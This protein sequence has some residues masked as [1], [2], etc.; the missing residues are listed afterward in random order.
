M[1][2]LRARSARILPLLALALLALAG[3]AGWWPATE[4]ETLPA[5]SATAARERAPSGT[6]ARIDE[7]RLREP[8]DGE[9]GAF[10]PLL[11]ATPPTWEEALWA[12]LEVLEADPAGA[13]AW[14][15]ALAAMRAGLRAPDEGWDALLDGLLLPLSYRP[16]LERLA[17][18]VLE[19][20]PVG[21]VGLELALQD[22]LFL[23]ELIRQG[24]EPESAGWLLLTA[25][26]EGWPEDAEQREDLR[27]FVQLVT[28]DEG[29]RE[30]VLDAALLR[31]EA[32]LFLSADEQQEYLDPVRAPRSEGHLREIVCRDCPY[33]DYG[34]L[35][36]SASWQTHSWELKPAEC[37]VYRFVVEA[38]ATYRFSLCD[39][40][41]SASFDSLLTAKSSRCLTLAQD[42]DS[43]GTA[44]EMVVTASERGYLYVQ[45]A[46]QGG[47]GGDYTLAYRREAAGSGPGCSGCPAYD[48]HLG[49]P[50]NQWQSVEGSIGADACRTYRFLLRLNRTYRFKTC[51]PEGSANFDTVIETD[52]NSANCFPGP[53]ND[54]AC[55]PQSSVTLTSRFTQY[56]TVS[57]RGFAGA[58]GDFELAYKD[59]TDECPTCPNYTV[60]AATPEAEWGFVEGQVT[61]HGCDLIRLYLYDGHSY[62]FT[63]CEGD[64]TQFADF[65]TELALLDENCDPLLPDAGAAC[66]PR[67]GLDYTACGDQVVYLRVGDGGGFGGAYRIAATELCGWVA[68]CRQCNVQ[69]GPLT[70]T[71]GWQVEPLNMPSG[72]CRVVAVNLEA[73][74]TYRFST[75]EGGGSISLGQALGLQVRQP[76]CGPCDGAASAGTCA[77]TAPRVDFTPDVTGTYYLVLQELAWTPGPVNLAYTEICADCTTPDNPVPLPIGCTY[78]TLS[79]TVSTGDGCDVWEFEVMPGQTYRFTLCP[80]DSDGTPTGASAGSGDWYLMQLDGGGN[81]C[82]PNPAECIAGADCN[83]SELDITATSDRIYLKVARRCGSFGLNYTLAY[84]HAAGLPALTPLDGDA[85]GL[86]WC[87]ESGLLT[88]PNDPDTDGDG[89]RDGD[90]VFGTPGGLDLPAMGADPRRKDLFIEYDWMEESVVCG[91][92]ASCGCCFDIGLHSHE[93][94]AAALAMVTTMFANAPIPNPDGSTGI[95]IHHDVGQGGAFTGGGMIG[96]DDQIDGG[97][98]GAE[99]AGYKA[100]NFAANRDNVFHYCILAHNYADGCSSGQAEVRGDDLIVTL[101][102]CLSDASVANTIAHELGHNLGLLHGGNVDCNW[103][104]NYNSIMNYRYQFPGIDDA[105]C[106]VFADGILDFSV[107]ARNTLDESSLDETVGVCGGVPVDWNEDGDGGTDVGIS[108]NVNLWGGVTYG[109][110]VGECGGTI[111]NL[112]D[113]DDWTL[114]ETLLPIRATGVDGWADGPGKAMPK[115]AIEIIDCDNSPRP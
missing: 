87:L 108:V 91:G 98:G 36:P 14:I 39:G 10:D 48:E 80:N 67:T 1:S 56:V 64:G 70:P 113:F 73:K 84:R 59:V 97:V 103:K 65:P 77:P 90:E 17:E 85:D 83:G 11:P 8:Q 58:G 46:D 43:C 110:E 3:A 30:H 22:R 69:A 88:D 2:E 42:D 109:G 107:G 71:T 20:R 105:G 61:P 31:D 35:Y 23:G 79:D 9:P 32:A 7:E 74:K 104:P 44:S 94:S 38:G 5:G 55:G 96:S 29:L 86:S 26:Q 62:R 92:A 60:T 18:A 114:V 106:N 37:K 41:G 45:V 63:F 47:E 101:Q 111:G 28:G 34:L 76:N 89:L 15:E 27:P 115:T 16:K 72:G 75:C 24:V 52:T 82:G 102:A 13:E 25:Q 53:S 4:A 100:A 19:G 50:T 57:V 21:L 40:G 33:W 6:V 112:G 68:G 51:G 49:T 81:P 78:S 66:G 99:F 12:R 95:T 93:P 54:D